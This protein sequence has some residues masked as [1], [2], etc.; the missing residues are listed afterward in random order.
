MAD[1][2]AEVARALEARKGLKFTGLY[3]W[4]ESLIMRLYDGDYEVLGATADGD[5]VDLRTTYG[6][7]TGDESEIIIAIYS[8]GK[9]KATDDEVRVTS[10]MR[11]KVGPHFDAVVKGDSYT[12]T[13][14]GKP[15]ESLAIRSQSAL[16]L[17]IMPAFLTSSGAS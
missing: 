14:E 16:R 5:R 17:V 8:P 2:A 15:G 4:G 7:S 11:I 1:K 3:V 6:S 10:A 9:V 13:R 12:I